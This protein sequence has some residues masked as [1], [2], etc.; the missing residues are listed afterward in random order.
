LLDPKAKIQDLY[1]VRGYPTTVFVGPEGNIEI[2]HIGIMTES[3]L[4]DY[5]VDLGLAP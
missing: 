4:D 2:I 5:L 1:Q 3:Q